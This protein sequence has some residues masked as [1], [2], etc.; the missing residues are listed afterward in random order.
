V[1]GSEAA[2]PSPIDF[3]VEVAAI[4]AAA[5]AFTKS[6]RVVRLL[7]LNLFS[8]RMIF[9]LSASKRYLNAD[10]HCSEK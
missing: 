4:P 5:A 9:R 10:V 7:N 2:C 6:R 1:P 3:E 8:E